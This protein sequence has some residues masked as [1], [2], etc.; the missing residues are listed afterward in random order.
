MVSFCLTGASLNRA[1][2][3]WNIT[4]KN[5]LIKKIVI[6]FFSPSGYEIRKNSPLADAVYYLPLDTPS[7]AREFIAL[8]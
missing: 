5:I 4:A 1:G 8:N 2:R 6:T 3:C 7:N